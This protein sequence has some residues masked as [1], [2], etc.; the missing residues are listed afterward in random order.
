MSKYIIQKTGSTVTVEHN[1]KP[2]QFDP[3]LKT[4]EPPF[5]CGDDSWG[6]M[7]LAYSIL[8]HAVGTNE[9]EILYHDFMYEHISQVQE[10][11]KELSSDEIKSFVDMKIKAQ[12]EAQEAI[13][14]MKKI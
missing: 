10:Y 14:N 12:W 4:A 11:P 2:L 3:K 8:A 7:N 1:N 9:A 6:S 13:K 5:S